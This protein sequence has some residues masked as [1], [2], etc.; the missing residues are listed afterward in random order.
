MAEIG[1][2][3][4]LAGI[5]SGRGTP[6]ATPTHYLGMAGTIKPKQSI[7]RPPWKGGKLAE[8]Y[9]S[10]I[11]RKWSEFDAEGPADVYLLP[12]LLNALVAGGIDGSG[13]VAATLITNLAGDNNNLE[14]TAVTAGGRGNAITVEYIDPGV[15]NSPPE[16]D[17]VG[18]AIKVW[19]A[20]DADGVITTIADDI[21]VLVAAHPVASVLVTMQDGPLQNGSGVVTAMAPTHLAGG[22]GADVTTPAGGTNSRIWTFEPDMDADTLDS[23]T[24]YWGDPNVQAF[25][26][27]FCMLDNLTI[28]ADAT[29]TDGVKMKF[30]GKGNF[31]A[32]Q[33]PGGVPAITSAPILL[34]GALELWIDTTS[35]IG[36][37]AITGRVASAESTFPSGISYKYLAAGPS[38]NLG[39]QDIGRGPRHSELKLKLELPDLTQYNQWVAH[40]SLKVRVRYNGPLIEG[41]LYHYFEQDIYGPMD[42]LDWGELENT[43]R[44]IEVAIL[45]HYNEVAGYDWCV[46]V[47]NDHDAL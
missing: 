16:L 35:D 22:S 36:T 8:F 3:Y 7:Y 18:N 40:D 32:K 47:Q 17:V 42:T 10:A 41:A 25:Q 43:N 9:K 4:L 30:S 6:L 15:I 38:G 31:P 19:L 44:T 28:T 12:L 46:R 1:F 27:A 14:Y 20:T 5:E 23:L 29:G 2:E 13:A 33:A 21:A 34:P 39:H 45:S 11:V 24:F 37:T 26:A